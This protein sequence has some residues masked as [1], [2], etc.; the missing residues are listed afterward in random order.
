MTACAPAAMRLGNI[1]GILDAAVG[2]DGHAGAL[3]RLGA[4]RHQPSVC[5]T[6]MPATIR[7]VQMLPGPIPTL[8]TSAPAS[9]RS[10]VAAAVATL[11]AMS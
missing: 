6:P 4:V 7:V 1:A 11:P 5:G 10:R 8:T 2:D 3:G 9:I